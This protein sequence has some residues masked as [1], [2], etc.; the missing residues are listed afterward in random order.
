MIMNNILTGGDAPHSTCTCI[1][2]KNAANDSPKTVGRIFIV[3]TYEAVAACLAS[4]SIRRVTIQNNPLFDVYSDCMYVY[5]T[6]AE[7]HL[8]TEA[9]ERY[10]LRRELE[11]LGLSRARIDQLTD[12]GEDNNKLRS[13]VKA[14]KTDLLRQFN[15][16]HK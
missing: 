10:Y 9:H 2:Y 16:A 12:D 13:L 14:T 4:Y 5:S 7:F 6:M 15:E 11:S 1:V 3:F 8:P